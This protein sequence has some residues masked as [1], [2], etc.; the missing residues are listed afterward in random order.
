MSSQA[1]IG[2]WTPVTVLAIAQFIMVLDTTVM[3]VSISA[4]VED[5][6][7]TVSG[8]QLA[9]TS[10]A[11]V[12]AAFMLTGGRLG[13]ILGRRRAFA[14]GLLIYGAGSLI[15]ALSPNLSVLLV[16][17][18]LVEGLGA[19]LVMPAIL[20]LVSATYSGKDR[21]IAYGILGG[22]AGAGAAAGPLIGGYVTTTFSW[23]YVFAAETVIVLG[24]LAI[25]LRKVANPAPKG[26]RIS[27][28]DVAMTASGM[29]AIVLGILQ[30]S[31]WG[32]IL[33]TSPPVVNGTEI[34]PLGL[35]PV[36]FIVGIGVLILALYGRRATRSEAR[37]G[38]PLL[39]PSLLGISQ[40]RNG[41]SMLT[42]TQLVLGGMF[43][44][45]PLFLQV[46]L[47]KDALQTG[48]EILP[49]SLAMVAS[50]VVG[51]RLAIKYSTRTVVMAGLLVLSAGLL[52]LVGTISPDFQSTEFSI[53]MAI[54]GTGLGLVISQLGNVIMSS[55]D[56]N[57]T[58]EAGGLQ[59]TA[60]NLGMALG[61]ALI[62][63]VLMAG[64][65]TGFKDRVASDPQ[66]PAQ[67][68]QLVASETKDG[69][70]VV[71]KS[72]AVAT[73]QAA[74]LTPTEV[75]TVSQHYMDAQIAALRKALAV[76]AMLALLGLF[77][78]K[79]LP[80]EPAGSAVND[81]TSLG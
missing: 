72:A 24:L 34:T 7:T 71:S 12:M 38:Q 37:D 50:S 74:G 73:A 21:A 19:T 60:Q 57:S 67:V 43:F 31:R 63:G 42:S 51:S 32:F 18:S 27:L 10:Y 44:T 78:A 17:W 29:A 48:I 30:A 64:L 47:E 69:V 16:G 14:I 4:V 2:K 25:G 33:P 36:P 80:A 23:R 41:L 3:N 13:D 52:I 58:G 54:A 49:L 28:V 70:Q 35:S 26:G 5:L 61:T 62:G 77:I 53:G 55:V 66:I 59:G 76:V 1:K 81:Q 68:Q 65:T 46:T 56:E 79:R 8:V 20:S 6:N 9:I 11:L 39:R 22:I 45:L 15:T 75:E 40:M